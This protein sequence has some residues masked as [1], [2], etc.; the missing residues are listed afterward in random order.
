MTVSDYYVSTTGSNIIG[1]GTSIKPWRTVTHAIS[2]VEGTEEN[3]IKIYI[4]RGTYDIASGEIFPL[5]MRSYVSIVGE[6][7]ETTII[8]AAKSG[9]SAIICR[10]YNAHHLSI[11]NLT[12]TGGSGYQE[13]EWY[14]YGGGIYLR[15]SSFI[16][17]ENCNIESNYYRPSLAVSEEL[18]SSAPVP[19]P[20]I[21][22]PTI[23]YG[24][25]I[26]CSSAE[27]VKIKNCI[28]SENKASEGGGI[29]AGGSSIELSDTIFSSNASPYSYTLASQGGAIVLA[30]TDSGTIK[31]CK[32][33]Y[34][35]CAQ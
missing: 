6:D 30:T 2:Q 19:M 27:S 29:Y 5:E 32:F 8:D 23:E 28:I 22:W 35:S 14:K 31:N 4:L 12:I 24:G 7:P 17:I 13:G 15:D 10:D 20:T 9:T 33:E 11:K 26:Y 1:N 25:G 34:N 16:T 18:E 3:N 21:P